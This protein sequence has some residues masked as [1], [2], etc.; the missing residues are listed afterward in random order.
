MILNIFLMVNKSYEVQNCV[1][2]LC[3]TPGKQKNA[4]MLYVV[5]TFLNHSAI[6]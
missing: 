1:F 5:I 3:A 6:S 2:L 4:Q